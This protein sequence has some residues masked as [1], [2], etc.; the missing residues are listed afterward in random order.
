MSKSYLVAQLDRIRAEEKMPAIGAGLVV[1]QP[2][3]ATGFEFITAASG[4]ERF[5][6]ATAVGPSTLFAL[7]SI[8]KPITGLLVARVIAREQQNPSPA[9]RWN[10]E[11]AEFFPQILTLGGSNRCYD[12]RTVA[13]LMAHTT[14]MPRV[15]AG[16]PPDQ[17]MSV[18]PDPVRR[19][20]MYVL[21]AVQDMPVVNCVGPDGQPLSQL[22]SNY[23]GGCIIAAHMTEVVTGRAWEDL[24]R[25]P[26]ATTQ[27]PGFMVGLLPDLS[28][29]PQPFAF[30]HVYGMDGVPVPQPRPGTGQ[31]NAPAGNVCVTVSQM[32]RLL[33]EFLDSTKS[34]ANRQLPDQE[35]PL[36][37]T[38]QGLSG[39]NRLGWRVLTLDTSAFGPVAR[40][41]IPALWHNGG[42][43]TMY[44]EAYV[45]PAQD[46]A[47]FV[48][49][50]ADG[51]YD[52]NSNLLLQHRPRALKKVFAE[53]AA[54]RLHHGEAAD[55][56]LQQKKDGGASVTIQDVS[57]KAA[58]V[59]ADG[60]LTTRWSA[61]ARRRTAT[62]TMAYEDVRAI[63][64]IV[65]VEDEAP[66]I[67]RYVLEYQGSGGAWHV[68]AKNEPGQD[69][70]F[71]HR[72][73]RVPSPGSRRPFRTSPVQA[74]KIRL[75]ILDV[76][77]P[78]RIVAIAAARLPGRRRYLPLW[79]R[80]GFAEALAPRGPVIDPG[81]M[82]PID[83]P[84]APK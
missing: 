25:H 51:P 2:R 33:T 1:P 65:I 18:E 67:R 7:G 59:I 44:A 10:T 34:D 29:E 40:W 57:P 21:A 36:L 28:V 80:K 30:G 38:P 12:R 32:A 20:T 61:P 53:L 72:I 23:A 81:P 79:W 6:E 22:P 14:G 82:L 76:T 60:R 63:D 42:N 66:N 75:R 45:A 27:G 5:G 68:V 11:L 9:L 52:S 69:L 15:P 78:P 47:M 84:A 26:G 71:P 56:V 16:E 17:W 49:L 74:R 77:A 3:S 19:R 70:I 83:R 31:T 39:F 50:N 35:R 41:V 13:D 62:I 8:S 73:F 37:M 43:G 24:T 64:R 58:A 46:T 54:L 4:V 55:I 48:M